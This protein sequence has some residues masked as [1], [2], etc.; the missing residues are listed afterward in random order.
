MTSTSEL[1]QKIG[2]YFSRDTTVAAVYLFGSF[3]HGRQRP[4]SDVD[5]AVLLTEPA[6][7]VDRK[8]FLDRLHRDLGRILRK[9]VH[10]LILNY[11]SYS[12]RMEALFRGKCAHVKDEEALARFRMVTVALFADFAPFLDQA[13]RSLARHLGCKDHG[14]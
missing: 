9:D 6:G 12:A 8:L 3:A 2:S 14:Q 4:M 11:A 10:L 1:L 5:I 7:A 13:H